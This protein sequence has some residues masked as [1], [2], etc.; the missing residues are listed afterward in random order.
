M[1]SAEQT[2]RETG[3]R[4]QTFPLFVIL[5]YPPNSS[6]RPE[7]SHHYKRC[8]KELKTQVF[9]SRHGKL[10]LDEPSLD[11]FLAPCENPLTARLLMTFLILKSK[12]SIERV[13][14][15]WRWSPVE[16]T[17]SILSDFT[18]ISSARTTLSLS[19]HME[20]E[21]YPLDSQVCGVHV[22]S[23]E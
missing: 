10:Q 4:R 11:L 16:F 18:I 23:C 19:C 14:N 17:D 9:P 15:F 22:T 3:H 13:R 5:V 7:T 2:R 8:H 12:P 20:F 21:E 1:H 6:P